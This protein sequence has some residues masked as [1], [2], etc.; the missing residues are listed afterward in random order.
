M[1]GLIAWR[2]CRAPSFIPNGSP[3]LLPIFIV[4]IETGALYAISVLALLVAF[5]TGSNGQFIAFD[6]ITPIVVSLLG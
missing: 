3:S 2:I 4:I 6:V 5:L 1:A